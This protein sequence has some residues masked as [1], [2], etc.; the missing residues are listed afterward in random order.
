MDIISFVLRQ[1]EPHSSV[2]NRA[3]RSRDLFFG[4]LADLNRKGGYTRPS[5]HHHSIYDSI[6][7]L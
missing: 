2:G 6:S 1:E 3:V 4:C 5:T 7:V